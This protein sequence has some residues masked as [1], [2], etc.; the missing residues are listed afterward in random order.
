M[1]N[2]HQC[3]AIAL[4]ISWYACGVAAGEPG[5]LDPAFNGSGVVVHEVGGEVFSQ[6]SNVFLLEDGSIVAVGGAN[7]TAALGWPPPRAGVAVWLAPDG[8]VQNSVTYDAGVWGCTAWRQFYGA[9]RLDNGEFIVTGQRQPTCSGSPQYLDVVHIRANGTVVRTFD[10]GVFYNAGAHGQALALQPDGKVVTAGRASTGGTETRDVALVRHH[11]A[12]GTLDN[13]FGVGGEVTFDIDGDWDRLQSVAITDSGKIVAAGFATTTN[14]RDF[15]IVR[16]EADGTLDTEF[17]TGGIV[18]YDFE[19]AEDRISDLALLSDGRIM[20]GGISTSAGGN[21]RFTVARFLASGV[22][23][24]TFADD[25]VALIDI[26]PFGGGLGAM[27][28][29]PDGRIYLAGWMRPIEDLNSLAPVL[30]VLSGDGTE[31]PAFG[32]PIMLDFGSEYPA[33]FA[34]SVSIDPSLEYIAVGGWVGEYDENDNIE[35]RRIAVARLFGIG[36]MIFR[37]RLEE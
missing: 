12:D 17:G 13:S 9:I 19:G 35:A 18:V 4:L 33:G 15:L 27:E 29:G 11:I 22:L 23:D 32:P 26:G 20:V 14:D 30:A 1:R 28:I 7:T 5:T 21:R 3:T 8:S 6:V 10:P 2:S 34:A 24:D 31:D 36:D 25:G 37:D 16:L